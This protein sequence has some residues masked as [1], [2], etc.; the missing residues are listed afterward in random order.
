[1]QNQIQCTNL[2]ESPDSILSL[3]KLEIEF[4]NSLIPYFSSFSIPLESA[5]LKK[6][7]LF[8]S[9]YFI[10]FVHGSPIPVSREFSLSNSK[11]AFIRVDLPTPEEPTK[12][13]FKCSINFNFSDFDKILFSRVLKDFFL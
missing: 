12:I 13:I 5:N 11:N 7:T 3:M 4:V 9:K 10:S 8:D 1:M 2:S 6:G